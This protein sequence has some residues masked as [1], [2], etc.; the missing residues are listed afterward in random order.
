MGS[1]CTHTYRY[2]PHIKSVGSQMQQDE[3]YTHLTYITEQIWLPHSNMAHMA[4]MLLEHIALSFLHIS[5]PKCP[6]YFMSLQNVPEKICPP[7]LPYIRH[8]YIEDVHKCATFE[9]CA[10]KTVLYNV[11]QSHRNN[12]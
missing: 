8:S 2:M 7:Y 11:V 10:L 9:A 1:V 6:I 5:T 3:L 4:N 12:R